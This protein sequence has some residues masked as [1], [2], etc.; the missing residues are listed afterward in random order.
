MPTFVV[1]SGYCHFVWL[2]VVTR[3]LLC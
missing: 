1:C 2:S 3:A